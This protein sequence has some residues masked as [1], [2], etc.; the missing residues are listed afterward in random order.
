MRPA[1]I[2]NPS[3]ATIVSRHALVVLSGSDY[4]VG[5]LQQLRA[6]GWSQPIPEYI[7][8]PFAMGPSTA[9][10]PGGSCSSSYEGF[11]TSWTSR[12]GDFC[13]RVSPH[14]DWFLHNGAGQRLYEDNGGGDFR[15]AMNPASAGWRSYVQTKVA[16]IAADYH[17][18]GLFLDNAWNTANTPR[19]R[20]SN[21]DGTCR[22]C[23]SDAQWHAAELGL[24]QGLKSAS[25]AR[26]LWANTDDLSQSGYAGPLDGI[27]WEDLGTGWCDGCW[28]SQASIEQH[29]AD[30]DA[31]VAA[32]DQVLFVGQGDCSCSTQQMRFSHALY[33]MVAGPRVSYRFQNGGDYRSLW[34]YP[35][36]S[37]NLGTPLGPRFKP[38]ATVFERTFS[39]G[40]ALANMG[41]SSVTINLGG[42]FILPDG[43]SATSVTLG[44]HQG[45][46]LRR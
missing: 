46:A 33:L 31:A 32:G 36:F 41:V 30:A 34:D 21:S 15:Y 26:P 6:A 2:N 3:P 17:M 8:S 39:N 19:N 1:D 42:T 40:A 12:A 28:E 18:D 44:A 22:E 43:S 35:E 24:L 27:M 29:L 45:V 10:N 4:E 25:G 37:W 14:E 38:V 13:N 7:Q 16:E 5:Y 23:G 20:M 9:L 11:T